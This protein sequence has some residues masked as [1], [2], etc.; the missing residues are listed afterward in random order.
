MT[1][2]PSKPE[3]RTT[4]AK[5]TPERPRT[6]ATGAVVTAVTAGVALVSALVA[7]GFQLW[8]TLKPDPREK[9]SASLSVFAV[10]PGVSYDAWLRRI[11]PTPNEYR[12]HRHT[13]LASNG[14]HGGS[15][16]NAILRTPGLVVYVA[17]EIHGFKRRSTT[18]RW[19]LYDEHHKRL[20]EFS[21]QPPVHVHLEAPTDR[22]IQQLWVPSPQRDGSYFVRV[23]L[24]V[25]DGAMLAVADT[26][27]FRGF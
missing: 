21:D 18:M 7:L 1:R 8:P 25:T 19:S 15:A 6:I 5:D 9:L 13:Y 20:P 4:A 22:T 24:L 23:E 2:P 10:D 3:H 27:R 11:S 16:A 26:P 14:V 12:R 17:S